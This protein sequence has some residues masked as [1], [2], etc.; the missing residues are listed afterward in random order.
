MSDWGLTAPALHVLECFTA[1]IQLWIDDEPIVC[2]WYDGTEKDPQLA[3][4][5]SMMSDVIVDVH[6]LSSV[7]HNLTTSNTEGNLWYLFAIFAK[8]QN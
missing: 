5:R 2:I 8:W 6:T 1:H 7:V 3:G 4:G